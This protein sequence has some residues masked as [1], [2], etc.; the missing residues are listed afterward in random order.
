MDSK[1]RIK[2]VLGNTDNKYLGLRVFK[3]LPKENLFDFIV[4]TGEYTDI[5]TARNSINLKDKS[6]IIF[7]EFLIKKVID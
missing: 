4:Y 1:V 2:G 5:T 6:K 3:K 7:P